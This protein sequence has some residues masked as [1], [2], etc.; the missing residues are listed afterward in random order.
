LLFAIIGGKAAVLLRNISARK[1][2]AS[3]VIFSIYIDR[4]EFKYWDFQQQIP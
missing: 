2:I 1:P 4:N 3:A